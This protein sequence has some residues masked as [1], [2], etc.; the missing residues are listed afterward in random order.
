MGPGVYLR[1]ALLTKFYAENLPEPSKPRWTGAEAYL[2]ASHE[3]STLAENPLVRNIYQ[4]LHNLLPS[5]AIEIIKGQR[6]CAIHKDL[7]QRILVGDDAGQLQASHSPPMRIL[8][9]AADD[10]IML[11]RPDLSVLKRMKPRDLEG[12]LHP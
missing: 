4:L 12:E 1:S 8:C 10:P 9:P 7:V 5:R 3:A 2:L 11:E 6:R